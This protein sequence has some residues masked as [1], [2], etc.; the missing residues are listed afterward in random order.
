VTIRGR[1]LY[2]VFLQETVDPKFFEKDEVVT[3]ELNKKALEPLGYEIEDVCSDPANEKKLERT[4]RI[5]GLT[6][7][8]LV[9]KLSTSGEGGQVLSLPTKEFANKIQICTKPDN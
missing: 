4:Y 1:G 6:T 2:D 5:N 9:N 3:D 7:R 8:E